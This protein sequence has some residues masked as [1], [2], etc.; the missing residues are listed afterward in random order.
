MNNESTYIKRFSI[1]ISISIFFLILV[2][3]SSIRENESEL[4]HYEQFR[5]SYKNK[6]FSFQKIPNK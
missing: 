5:L 2:G 1:S 6:Y 3:C 4:T